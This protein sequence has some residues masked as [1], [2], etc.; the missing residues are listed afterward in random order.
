MGIWDSPNKAKPITN[1]R[2]SRIDYNSTNEAKP[3]INN[4]TSRIDYIQ[5]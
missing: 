4:N 3:T 5:K 2:T 1:N